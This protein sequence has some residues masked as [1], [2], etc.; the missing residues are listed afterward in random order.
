ML[1][2]DYVLLFQPNTDGSVIA[3][4]VG[5][6]FVSRFFVDWEFREGGMMLFRN[7]RG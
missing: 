2:I 4:A 5:S 6:R 1:E 3:I 7:E